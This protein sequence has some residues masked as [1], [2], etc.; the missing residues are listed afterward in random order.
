MNVRF[1]LGGV[2]VLDLCDAQRLHPTVYYRW[3]KDFFAV[4]ASTA[5]ILDLRQQCRSAAES[6]RLSLV[7]IPSHRI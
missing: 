2:A 5:N 3:Q 1:L 7:Q 6:D 4:G